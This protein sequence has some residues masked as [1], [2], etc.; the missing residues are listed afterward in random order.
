VPDLDALAE[1]V[2]EGR[3]GVLAVLDVLVGLERRVLLVVV[4]GG[5]VVGILRR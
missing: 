5:E 1:Q 3:V 4:P 2:G